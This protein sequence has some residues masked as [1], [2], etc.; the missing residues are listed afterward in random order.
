MRPNKD[1]PKFIVKP[2]RRDASELRYHRAGAPGTRWVCVDKSI[3]PHAKIYQ[4]V[5]RISKLTEPPQPYIEEH[6]HCVDSTFIFL[7]NN[8]DLTGLR[9]EVVL[10]GERFEINSPAT[11]YIPA[12]LVHSYRLSAGSG[13]FIHTVLGGNYEDT[14]S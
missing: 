8:L 11:V 4:I 9:A 13:F 6:K 12:G 5:R 2:V 3:Y 10:N 7:G 14:L 1:L